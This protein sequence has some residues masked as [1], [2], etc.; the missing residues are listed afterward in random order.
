IEEVNEPGKDLHL[1]TADD[2][3]VGFH[4]WL[5]I[6]SARWLKIESAPTPADR[7]IRTMSYCPCPGVFLF[8]INGLAALLAN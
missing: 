4:P 2:L 5:N 6:E 7:Y 1:S 8:C 3:D